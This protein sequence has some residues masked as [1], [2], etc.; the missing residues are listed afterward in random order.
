[1]L[2]VAVPKFVKRSMPVESVVLSAGSRSVNSEVVED[3]NDI[4][5]KSLN[6]RLP[7]IT[8]RAVAR[9]L[10]KNAAAKK[11]KE[12]NIKIGKANRKVGLLFFLAFEPDERFA[13]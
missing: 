9:M 2:S 13:F 4:A 7:V 8:A 10:V 1:M 5:K 12:K 11:A 3:V 6:D